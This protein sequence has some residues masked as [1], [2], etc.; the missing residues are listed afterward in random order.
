M[1]T[2]QRAGL[3]VGL[4]AMLLVSL[5]GCVTPE[6]GEQFNMLSTQEEVALGDKISQEVEKKEKILNDP[7]IQAYV[8]EIGARIAKQ[9][10]RTDVPYKF[11]VI[12]NPK[13][14]NAFALPGGHMYIYT[15]L[16]KLCANEAELASVMGHE[17]AHVAA[18]H[19]GESMTRQYG[20]SLIA[21]LILGDSPSANAELMA[22]IVGSL[23]ESKFSRTQENE[24]DRMGMDFLFRAGYKPEAMVTFMEKM[25]ASEGGGSGGGLLKYLS[26][27]PP[28]PER[29]AALQA[30]EQQYPAD[31]R[32][33]SAAYPERYWDNV[34]KRLN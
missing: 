23:G 5:P 29:I 12:D 26:S 22:Q 3:S 14:V 32:A 6:G 11:T 16:M 17:I 31:L 19:H 8:R 33:S 20:Y 7:A 10:P 24:A 4:L 18:H 15:G 2:L 9:S 27:H 1:K 30:Q 21:S 34:L 28:T 13:T 25:N